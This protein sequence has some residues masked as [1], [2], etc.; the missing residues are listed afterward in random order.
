MSKFLFAPFMMNLGESQRLS[1]L[2]NYLYEQGHD[3]HILGD[4]YYP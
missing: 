4:N 1:K 2:A 3:I